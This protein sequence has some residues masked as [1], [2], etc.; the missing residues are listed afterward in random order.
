MYWVRTPPLAPSESGLESD[1]SNVSVPSPSTSIQ[2]TMRLP[3]PSDPAT[4]HNRGFSCPDV[5]IADSVILSATSEDFHRLMS[6]ALNAPDL[7][8]PSSV[9]LTEPST[10]SSASETIRRTPRSLLVEPGSPDRSSCQDS[11]TTPRPATRNE[12]NPTAFETVWNPL[13]PTCFIPILVLVAIVGIFIL[14]TV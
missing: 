3:V 5:S 6:G 14:V 12:G 7:I 2:S 8:P 11:P 1:T 4:F 13:S 10:S 9:K